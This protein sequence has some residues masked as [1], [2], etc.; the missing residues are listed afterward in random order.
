LFPRSDFALKR[1]RQRSS[2]AELEQP[3]LIACH[4]FASGGWQ[5]PKCARGMAFSET[6]RF[7]G[8]WYREPEMALAFTL[9]EGLA[10]RGKTVDNTLVKFDPE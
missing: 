2:K 8:R 5:L 6:P 7:G 9:A 3:D 1:S 4:I 10:A